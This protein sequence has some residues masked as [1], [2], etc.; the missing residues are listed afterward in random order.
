VAKPYQT[1][2]DG[3]CGVSLRHWIAIVKPQEET[4]HLEGLGLCQEI[5]AGNQE[6]EQKQ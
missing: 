5:T 4:Q 2:C 1:G 6:N 3:T